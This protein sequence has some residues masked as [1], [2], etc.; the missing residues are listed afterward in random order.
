MIGPDVNR[1]SRGPHRPSCR[2]RRHRHCPTGFHH[3]HQS[4][5]RPYD[6]RPRPRQSP[7][8]AHPGPLPVDA[9][10]LGSDPPVN[11]AELHQAG[12]QRRSLDHQRPRKMRALI[13][14]GVDGII[15]DRPDI[16]RHVVKEEAQPPRHAA[17]FTTFD[18]SAHRGG[19]G[20]RPR[21]RYPPSRPASTS[22]PPRSRPTPVSPPTTSPLIWHD[23]FLNP[24]SCRRAD[25]TPTLSKTASTSATSLSPKRSVPS[26]AISST[27][28]SPIRSTISPSRPHAFAA[29]EHLI[30]PYVPTYVEQ[31]FRF[32]AFYV[33]YYRTGPGK[34]HPDAADAP[35]TQ[36]KPAS[37]S[38]PRSSRCPTTNPATP[39]PPQSASPPPTTPST[40][41]SSS[42]HSPSHRPQPHGR[43]RRNPELRLP[44]PHPSE[45][46]FPKIPTYYLTASPKMLSTEFVPAALRQQP[47]ANPQRSE[48]I[49]LPIGATTALLAGLD[50]Q[51]IARNLLSVNPDVTMLSYASMLSSGDFFS[52][53]RLAIFPGSIV[54]TCH[55]S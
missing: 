42:R 48:R 3:A 33:D 18:I 9:T 41:K 46:Q 32:T 16:L 51:T 44:H 29:H 5:P 36:P 47:P 28:S 17:Y 34:S 35:P 15:T 11:V 19:R 24:Q 6:R 39:C 22:S 25:G 50:R 38:K 21:T 54:P 4:L 55:R 2:P 13:A 20:L 49:K 26:S 12:F 27:P 45:E 23:Q 37:T 40:L 52:R 1:F 43:S 8:R 53:T 30:N 7:R 10:L 14:L 31:L